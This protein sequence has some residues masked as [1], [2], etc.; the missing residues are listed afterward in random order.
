M[1][2]RSPPSITINVHFGETIAELLQIPV[3]EQQLKN[4]RFLSKGIAE[5]AGLPFGEQEFFFL[6][7][8]RPVQ[9]TVLFTNGA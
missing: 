9:V 8:D 2:S 5:C 4:I 6:N 1:I 7:M 3:A